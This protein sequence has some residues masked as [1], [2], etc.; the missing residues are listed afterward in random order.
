MSRTLRITLVVAVV[1][2]VT[3]LAAFAL[4]G[5]GV[6]GGGGA[7][8]STS[9]RLAAWS[10]SSADPTAFTIT[11]K[12]AGGQISG[13]S[14]VNSYG[15]PYKAT[16]TG[17]FESGQIASTLM[18]GPEDAMR[19]EQLFFELLDQVERYELDGGTLTLSD[20]NGNPLLIFEEAR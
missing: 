2:S 6:L 20:A 10:A 1:V 4:L 3:A 15:G 5:Q 11:V 12:F 8:D 19:A 14:A 18:A 13:T 17:R 16:R 9:W 7:L